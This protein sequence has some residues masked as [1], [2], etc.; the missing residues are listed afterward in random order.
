ME[1]FIFNN[2][3]GK[4]IE[5]SHD[6]DYVLQAVD[7]TG[8]VDV[9]IQSKSAYRQDGESYYGNTLEPRYIDLEI[10]IVAGSSS[11][12]AKK[13]RLLAKILS[14]KLGPGT[15]Y[16]EY[17]GIRK[18]IRA[19]PERSPDFSNVE[20]HKDFMQTAL[21][22]F[23]CPN[24]YWIEES[25]TRVNISTEEP[26]IEFPL[27]IPGE[28]LELSIRTISFITNIYNPGDTDTPIRIILEATESV[29]NP[30]VENLETGEYVRVNR[31]LLKGDKLEIDTSYGNKRVEIIRSNGDRENAFNYIDY[32]SSFFSI[33]PGDSRIKYDAEAGNGNL[34][35]RIY[36]TPRYMGV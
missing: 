17:G 7:G 28:G 6:T 16:Y 4:S 8:G 13:R 30:I 20:E 33:D 18:L 11:E 15:L 10:V 36:Y 19:L 26:N 25:S 21:I 23:Y 27:Q 22:G 12:M 34:D 9:N 3:K 5:L 35:V 2:A 31:R 1:K 32:K 29:I 14:P 24:P